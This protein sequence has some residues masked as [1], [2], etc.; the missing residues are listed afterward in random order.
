MEQF[1]Q[2]YQ[3]DVMGKLSGFDRLM[4]RGTQRALANVA[5]MMSYLSYMGVLLKDFGTFVD[6]TSSRLKRA[7]LAAAQRLDRPIRYLPSS[8][9]R[10]EKVAREIAA[11]DGIEEGLICILSCVEPCMS[12]SVGGDRVSKKLVLRPCLRKCLHLY[13]YWMDKDFG[14]MHG[15]IQTWFP[16]SIQVCLNGRSWLARQM[17]RRGLDYEQRENSFA[18]LENVSAAQRLMDKLL[19][20]NW[21]KFL[22]RIARRI[23]PIQKDILCG[24]RTGYYWS[25]YE[26]E[27]ATDIMFKSSPALAKIYPALVRGGIEVFSSESVMRFLGK[28]LNGHFRGEVISDYRRRPEGVRIKHS[29]KSNSVKMYDKQGSILRVETTINNPYDFKAY[30]PKEG[31]PGGACEWRYL[32]KGIADLHRRAEIADGCNERYLEALAS[33]TTDEP[34]GRLVGSVCRSK[35]RKGRRVRALRPWSQEDNKL[36]SVISRGEFVIRGFRNRDLVPYLYPAVGHNVADKRRASGRVTRKLR[37]LRA[38]GIIRKVAGT[39]RYLL[40]KKGRAIA[41]AIIEYQ[42][43]TLQELNKLSA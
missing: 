13:H 6:D 26:S 5:G 18:W 16:F 28:K 12:Y 15:R 36:L 38:H 30:R 11:R 25:V 39:H 35:R 22:D 20:L 42:N 4:I 33:I 32:R 14:L 9:T 8:Q 21:S 19:R 34:L 37:L 17:D 40:T 31:D 7:S 1:I 10:K 29:V 2:K 24:Y 23:N 43:L 3:Q 41:T 27:W